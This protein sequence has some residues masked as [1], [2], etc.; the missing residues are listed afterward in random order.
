MLRVTGVAMMIPLVVMLTLKPFPSVET[1]LNVG[2][3]IFAI[4]GFYL[5]LGKIPMAPGM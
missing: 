4:A 5:L 2:S 1:E 3:A